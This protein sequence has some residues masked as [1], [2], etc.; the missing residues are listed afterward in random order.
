[1]DESQ[2]AMVAAKLAT[3]KLGG[4]DPERPQLSAVGASIRQKTA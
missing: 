1:L 2:R 3:L 4:I